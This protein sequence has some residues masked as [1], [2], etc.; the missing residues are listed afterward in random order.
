MKKISSIFVFLLVAV[1]VLTACG[2]A[3][4]ILPRSK[5]EK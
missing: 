4:N 1:L 5:S 3:A 2:P